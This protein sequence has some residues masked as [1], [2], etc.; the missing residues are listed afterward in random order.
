MNEWCER[1]KAFHTL[2]DIVRVMYGRLSAIPN[3]PL[4][5][6]IYQYMW[7]AKET[8]LL[9][10]SY[11]SWLGGCGMWWAWPWLDGCDFRWWVW[12]WWGGVW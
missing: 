4:L 2:C 5:Y 6:D 7:D 3:R 8:T 10:D 11:V 9:L 12:L 1:C